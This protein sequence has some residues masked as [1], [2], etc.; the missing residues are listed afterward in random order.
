MTIIQRSP[1][2]N[3]A[4]KSSKNVLSSL[5]NENSTIEH[6]ENSPENNRGNK[7]KKCNKKTQIKKDIILL[8]LGGEITKLL[9]QEL[10]K[11]FKKAYIN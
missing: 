7:F 9:Q 2:Q 3:G 11:N 4:P 8:A 5:L 10:E 1:H 6:K